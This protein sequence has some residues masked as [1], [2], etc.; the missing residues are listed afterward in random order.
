MRFLNHLLFTAG[1]VATTIPSEAATLAEVMGETPLY[2]YFVNFEKGTA[3]WQKLSTDTEPTDIWSETADHS[4]YVML[5]GWMKNNLLCGIGTIVSN[6]NVLVGYRYTQVNPLSG[7]IINETDYTPYEYKIRFS[8]A[9][10]SKIDDTIY[11][12]G[13][14]PEEGYY[15]VWKKT[16]G[17]GDMNNMEYIHT[18]EDPYTWSPVLC[19]KPDTDEIYG[20]TFNGSFVKINKDGTQTEIFKLDVEV[21]GDNSALTY[22]SSTGK[23]LWSACLKN[24]ST[25]LYAIDKTTE[26]CELIEELPDQGYYAFFSTGEEASAVGVPEAPVIDDVSFFEG[27][28][29]GTV[30]IVLPDQ[31][32]TGDNISGMVKWYS[33]VDGKSY[34]W[35][36]ASVG[37]SVKVDF[38]ELPTGTRT[39]SFSVEYNGKEGPQASVTIYVGNDTPLATRSVTLSAVGNELIAEWD[40]VT[41]GVHQGWIDLENITYEVYLNY[42]LMG[43]T[44]ET[45]WTYELDHDK[46]YTGYQVGIVVKCNEMQSAERRSNMVSAGK[47]MSLPFIIEPTP[48]QALLMTYIAD[49]YGTTWKYDSDI[50]PAGFTSGYYAD[51]PVDDWLITPPLALPTSAGHYELTFETSAYRDYWGSDYYEVGD[52]EYYDVWLGTSPTANGMTVSLVDKTKVEDETILNRV[53]FSVEE[54]GT[55]YVGFHGLSE[56]WMPG[57]VIRNIKIA[58]EINDGTDLIHSGNV[59]IEGGKGQITVIGLDGR[60]VSIYT[61]AGQRVCSLSNNTTVNVASGIYLVNVDGMTRKVVV[62]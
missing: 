21:S 12:F 24:G 1:L 33:Y 13:M 45:T 34:G 26:T 19:I 28:T 30:N 32:L 57:I 53:D 2:G 42:E 52:E 6:Q 7:E 41:A 16:T 38:D 9:V 56:M 51:G 36:A 8:S 62:K 5:T 49:D 25:A 22:I 29:S 37:K 44:K 14:N 43:E 18:L 61:L 54:A 55:Y 31:T 3:T 4:S 50:E 17:D 47:P 39:L 27:S 10:Y 20:I 59:K 23:F 46:P 58:E 48:E 35:G 15:P 40:A 60:S 11:G